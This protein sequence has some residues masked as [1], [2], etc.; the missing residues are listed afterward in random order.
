[1]SNATVRFADVTALRETAKAL[2]VQIGK[3]AY[4]VPKSAIHAD[5][6]VY[7]AMENNEGD[8]VVELWWAEKEGL[9]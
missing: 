4:W 2:L 9:E 3:D 1:M 7:G 5:S 8:L 6:E